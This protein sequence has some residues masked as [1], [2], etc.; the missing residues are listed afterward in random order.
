MH[1]R[2]MSL[3]CSGPCWHAWPDRCVHR[4]RHLPHV[5]FAARRQSWMPPLR[6]LCTSGSRTPSRGWGR[7]VSTV[8]PRPCIPT[9]PSSTSLSEATL[10]TTAE[11]CA[12]EERLKRCDKLAKLHRF[13]GS[14]IP[15]SLALGPEFDVMPLPLL[16]LPQWHFVFAHDTQCGLQRGRGRGT[17]VAGTELECGGVEYVE[18]ERWDW[19]SWER[20]KEELGE[21]EKASLPTHTGLWRCP[22]A[23]ALQHTPSLLPCRHLLSSPASISATGAVASSGSPASSPPASFGQNQNQAPYRQNSK[24]GSRMRMQGRVRGRLETIRGEFVLE[25]VRLVVERRVRTRGRKHGK[26]PGMADSDSQEPLVA[27]AEPSTGLF[28]YKH[29]QHSLNSLHDILDRNDKES[30]AELQQCLS[31]TS[32][33]FSPILLLV[34]L[35]R[36]PTTPQLRRTALAPPDA[37]QLARAKVKTA[38]RMQAIVA[39]KE[40]ISSPAAV[41]IVESGH[42]ASNTVAT[43]VA[44]IA[45][46]HPELTSLDGIIGFAMDATK[47]GSAA[48]DAWRVIHGKVDALGLNRTPR[49]LA[50]FIADAPANRYL[51]SHLHPHIVFR[52]RCTNPGKRG[53]SLADTKCQPDDDLIINEEAGYYI[54]LPGESVLFVD[55]DI[56]KVEL[57]VLR[58]I[59]LGSSFS[60]ELYEHFRG[61]I[62]TACSKRRNVQPRHDGEMVQLL[63]PAIGYVGVCSKIMNYIEHWACEVRSSKT[64]K[65]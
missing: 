38:A 9:S 63:L 2:S 15:A 17:R 16:R 13:L 5:R 6:H 24:R 27:N 37:R 23:K 55:P 49:S 34:P 12:D 7:G 62:A 65:Y 29:Y 20:L 46:I 59:L 47:P 1:A 58:G 36:T 53:M 4:A 33:D 48:G 56:Y 39:A 18:R 64:A 22:T 60:N 44:E 45:T 41:A 51:S 30:L 3:L 52:K 8:R 26:R 40:F 61:V 28:V 19:G 42:P 11:E 57:G 31:D 14:R 54:V 35:C 21:R 25:A 50:E 10:A 32:A 43:L